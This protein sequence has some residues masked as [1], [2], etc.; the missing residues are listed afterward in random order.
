MSHAT[1]ALK[2]GEYKSC[3][4]VLHVRATPTG[5]LI[6]I[7][8]TEGSVLGWTFSEE[9]TFRRIKARSSEE[10]K[11]SAPLGA[12]LACPHIAKGFSGDILRSASGPGRLG[13]ICC[14]DCVKSML[15]GDKVYLID[16][17]IIDTILSSNILDVEILTKEVN[18]TTP[19]EVAG[20]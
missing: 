4:V 1:V 15:S 3:G 7:E 5:S 14:L 6:E 11:S 10:E 8:Q 20:R 17:E 18:G 13:W 9:G 2:P 12:L 16:P 19:E